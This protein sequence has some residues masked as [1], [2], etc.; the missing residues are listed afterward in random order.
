MPDVPSI[1]VRA[2]VDMKRIETVGV[3]GST[4]SRLMPDLTCA[5]SPTWKTFSHSFLPKNHKATLHQG[6]P[7]VKSPIDIE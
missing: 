4:T 6:S 2:L 5:R 7:I 1:A 3:L